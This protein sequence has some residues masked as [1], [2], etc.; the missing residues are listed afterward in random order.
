MRPSFLSKSIW[1]SALLWGMTTLSIVQAQTLPHIELS[2][3]QRPSTHWTAHESVEMHPL[4]VTTLRT[5]QGSGVLLGK[6]GSPLRTQA[7]VRD[8]RLQLEFMLSPGAEGYVELPGGVRI[9]LNDSWQQASPTERTLGQVAGQVPTQNATKAPGLWQRMSLAYDA[10]LPGQPNRWK[11]DY[12]TL[13]GVTVQQAVYGVHTQPVRESAPIQVAV[14]KGAIALRGFFLQPLEEKRPLTLQ[15]LRYTLYKD[16]WDATAP[17]SVE[18]QGAAPAIT[19]EVGQGMREFHVVFEGT[20]QVEDEGDYTFTT[21]YTGP[22]CQLTIG[23]NKVVVS[24]GSTSQETHTGTIR[25]TKGSHPFRLWYSRF[26]WRAPALGV[27]VEKAGIRPYDLHALSSLPEP[28]PKPYVTVSPTAERA[29]MLRSFVQLPGE[30]TKRTHCLSVGSPEGWHYTLDLNRGAWLMAWRGEFADVTEMWYERGE[31]Q[32]LS[33]AGLM[34]PVSGQSSV[35]VLPSSSATWPD[36]SNIRFLGYSLDRKGSP[37]SSYALEGGKVYDA[38]QPVS[39][40]IQRSLRAENVP[41][42]THVLAAKGSSIR[43][44]EKGLYLVGDAYYVQLSA[45]DKP[46]LRSQQGQKEL[47]LPLTGTVSYRLFW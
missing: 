45:K 47:L 16:S 30:P 34:V 42:S 12:C 5:T 41:A 24:G 19:Q 14:T 37:T 10:S 13:N 6:P 28:A 7:S 35:A 39:G 15:G 22:T 26:P 46:V 18:R 23:Q 29:E 33:P 21:L 17:A 20:M 43:L 8:L 38:I 36:S 3:F 11:L 40:G 9:L 2:L 1:V 44:V 25:L 31:P 27:R 32:L 4:K